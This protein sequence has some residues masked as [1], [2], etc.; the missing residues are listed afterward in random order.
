MYDDV[1]SGNKLLVT[2]PLASMLKIAINILRLSAS[3][4]ASSVC[5]IYIACSRA[6]STL[7]SEVAA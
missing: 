1:N 6:I 2:L 7:I 4:S 5:M 3:K